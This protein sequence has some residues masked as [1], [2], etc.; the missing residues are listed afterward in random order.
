MREEWAAL[1][2]SAAARQTDAQGELETAARDAVIAD[3]SHCGLIAATGPEAQGFLHSQLTSDVLAVDATHSQLAAYL[4]PKGRAL[5]LFR[6]W[7]SAD[8][9][10]L[11]LPRDLIE[12]TLRRLRMYVLRTK[13]EL[14]DASDERVL[15]GWAPAANALGA[16]LALPQAA[17]EARGDADVT[18]VNLPGPRARYLFDATPA[19]AVGLWEALRARPVG[20]PAWEWLEIE[21]GQPQVYSPTVESF[22]PQM[23]NLDR[24]NGVSFKK[25]CYPGQEIVARLRYL[26]QLKRRM[27]ALHCTSE[28]LP[29]PGT[30]LYASA[31]A[32]QASGEVVRA[33]RAPRGGVDMLAVV[34]LSIRALPQLALGTPAGPAC[35]FRPLPYRTDD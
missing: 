32:Q 5:A 19:A 34:E 23:L 20:T 12:P 33:A 27:T 17:D 11:M 35:E 26:G 15:L 21:A 31:E 25:G 16:P 9:F 8:E 24:L 3:L 10:R 6:I 29:P 28:I 1:R 4:T 18:V 13:V 14:R 2:R 7:R 22:I 30:P